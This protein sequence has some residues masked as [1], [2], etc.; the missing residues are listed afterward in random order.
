MGAQ[1]PNGLIVRPMTGEFLNRSPVSASGSTRG[2][3][4]PMIAAGTLAG[5]YQGEVLTSDTAGYAGGGGAG[6]FNGGAGGGAG[7]FGLGTLG[8]INP[9]APGIN[10][11]PLGYVFSSGVT[12]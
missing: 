6:A 9:S 12:G 10:K 8:E 1:L 4:N 5:S 2:V 11:A 3:E 7:T